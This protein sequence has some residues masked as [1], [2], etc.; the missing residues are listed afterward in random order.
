VR[1][2]ILGVSFGMATKIVLVIH[3]LVVVSTAFPMMDGVVAS[4]L[5]VVS[6]V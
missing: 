5:A 3:E 1:G 2:K 4:T 6:I